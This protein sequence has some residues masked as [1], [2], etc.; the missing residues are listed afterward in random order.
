MTTANELEKL[1][2]EIFERYINQCRDPYDGSLVDQ[3]RVLDAMQASIVE[4]HTLGKKEGRREGFEAGRKRDPE[5]NLPGM[6]KYKTLADY[7]KEGE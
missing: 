1:H 6:L 5:L 4:A 3:Q 7:E 2:K